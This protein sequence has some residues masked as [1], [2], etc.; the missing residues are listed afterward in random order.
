M[1][2]QEDIVLD[3]D[4]FFGVR[5]KKEKFKRPLILLNQNQ[6]LK[7]SPQYW[8]MHVTPQKKMNCG[9]LS[10]SLYLLDSHENHVRTI[11]R[12]DETNS[13]EEF[14]NKYQLMQYLRKTSQLKYLGALIPQIKSRD[15]TAVKAKDAVFLECET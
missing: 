9:S 11:D 7:T 6:E 14:R 2:N 10:P 12:I 1:D 15:P 5:K 3:L 4:D 8:L 13:K